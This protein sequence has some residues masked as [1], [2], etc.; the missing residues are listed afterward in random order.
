MENQYPRRYV[1]SNLESQLKIHLRKKA[2]PYAVPARSWEVWRTL[3]LGS[4]LSLLER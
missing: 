1:D 4:V 2:H 3:S